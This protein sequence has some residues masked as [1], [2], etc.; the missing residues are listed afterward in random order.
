MLF[1]NVLPHL[2]NSNFQ[3]I[4]NGDHMIQFITNI[5]F[6]SN[7]ATNFLKISR[8][9]DHKVTRMSMGSFFNSYT[10]HMELLVA[11]ISGFAGELPKIVF[12]HEVLHPNLFFDI[13][14]Q[15]ERCLKSMKNMKR[16][17]KRIFSQH[18]LKNMDLYEKNQN[19]GISKA[20][21]NMCG[22]KLKQFLSQIKIRGTYVYFQNEHP[23]SG[24]RNLLDSIGFW[25]KYTKNVDMKV[26]KTIRLLST[27]HG[28][29]STAITYEQAGN[30]VCEIK[31]S[32]FLS[33]KFRYLSIRNSILKLIRDTEDKK[34][35]LDIDF[36]LNYE[37]II[38][39][40]N[41][42]LLSNINLVFTLTDHMFNKIEGADI[43][44]EIINP[45][46][47]IQLNKV[48]GKVIIYIDE[49]FLLN[50]E[51][52]KMRLVNG[53][54]PLYQLY[55]YSLNMLNMIHVYKRSIESIIGD[56]VVRLDKNEE[57]FL[58]NH[59]II[60]FDHL[61]VIMFVIEKMMQNYSRLY[62][63]S[64]LLKKYENILSELAEYRD[65]ICE[66]IDIE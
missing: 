12:R 19:I 41:T 23:M 8:L 18:L 33:L 45:D 31:K 1:F 13:I 56:N 17:C 5:Q 9:N 66:F 34:Y 25:S 47:Y 30:L 63:D 58:E 60:I 37:S 7:F 32:D 6:I 44:G 2:C 14:K 61:Q 40:R 11:N 55:N 51:N 54:K 35:P 49:L 46:V 50:Q 20:E 16:S 26:L 42:S 65:A 29:I 28:L 38:W 59:V 24:L 21:L 15:A 39:L 3:K 62:P 4:D 64:L 43:S 52:L 10:H 48:F 36:W 53:I 27:L 57:N 22:I